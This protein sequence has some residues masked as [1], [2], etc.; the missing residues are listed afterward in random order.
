MK[1]AEIFKVLGI[2]MLLGCLQISCSTATQ[3]NEIINSDA[4]ATKQ[5]MEAFPKVDFKISITD[6]ILNFGDK[7]LLNLSLTNNSDKEQKLLFDK[8]TLSTGGPWGITGN[9]TDIY[10]KISVLKHE[11]KAMLSSQIYTEDELKDKYYYLKPGQTVSGQYE[12]KDIVVLNSSDNSLPKGTYEV[13]LF[14]HFN[15]SN[16][17]TIK[18]K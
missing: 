10:M 8:P 1:L 11:N 14:Y 6:T 9:V 3:K 5:A 12:L 4:S 2:T 17:L 13:Q 7:I 15:P 16:I 18:I